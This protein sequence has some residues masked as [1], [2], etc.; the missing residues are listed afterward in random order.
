M[1]SGSLSKSIYTVLILSPLEYQ[2]PPVQMRAAA[3]GFE[4]ALK[5]ISKPRTQ[6]LCPSLTALPPNLALNKWLVSSAETNN[7]SLLFENVKGKESFS[8][9]KRFLVSVNT[10]ENLKKR[11]NCI[12]CNFWAWLQGLMTY[13][14]RVAEVKHFYFP[15]ACTK[16]F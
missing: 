9:R 2:S 10:L 12:S 1:F 7:I 4:G 8:T 6:I 11:A 16:W 13:L 5:Q 14:S 3:Q 15:C